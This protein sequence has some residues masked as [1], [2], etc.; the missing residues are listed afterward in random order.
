MSSTSQVFIVDRG[1]LRTIRGARA[2]EAAMGVA[3]ERCPPIVRPKV[4]ASHAAASV[5]AEKHPYNNLSGKARIH[6]KE[7]RMVAACAQ[8]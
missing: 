5:G 7:I 3:G 2:L 8:K 6:Q 1:A 4:S